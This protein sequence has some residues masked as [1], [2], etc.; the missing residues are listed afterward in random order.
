MVGAQRTTA[1]LVKCY[2]GTARKNFISRTIMLNRL[3]KYQIM[4]VFVHFDLPTETKRIGR[5]GKFRKFLY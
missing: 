5:S 1:S 3:N 2:Q 4:W